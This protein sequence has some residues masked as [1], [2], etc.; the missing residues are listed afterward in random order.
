MV[1]EYIEIVFLCDLWKFHSTEKFCSNKGQ[2]F[3]SLRLQIAI[4]SLIL[5]LVVFKAPNK[6]SFWIILLAKNTEYTILVGIFVY[7]LINLLKWAKIIKGITG[8]RV[9]SEK[10]SY[11][12]SILNQGMREN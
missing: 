4:T 11:F 7:S 8:K 6:K 9:I 5:S 12:F 2:L 10:F 1:V 3:S